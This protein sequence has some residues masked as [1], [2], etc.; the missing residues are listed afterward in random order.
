MS[1]Q[2]HYM[3]NSGFC[4]LVVLLTIGGYFLTLKRAG[5]KWPFWMILMA[6]WGLLAIAN[7]LVALGINREAT[8]VTGIWLS[9]FVLVFASLVLLFIKLIQIVNARGF[10]TFKEVAKGK[11]S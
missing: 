7:S 9:S 11:D 1:T 6:G 10:G 8:Y 2:F 3:L 4:W 5:Q